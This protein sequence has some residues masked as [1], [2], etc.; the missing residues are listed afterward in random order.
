[1][2]RSLRF[3]LLTLLPVAAMI[4]C[5]VITSLDDLQGSSITPDAGTTDAVAKDAADAQSADAGPD[6]FI[7][8]S[9]AVDL[10]LGGALANGDT[11]GHACA[12]AGAER[13]LYCWGAGGKGQLGNGVL[14]DKA[15]AT[16]ILSDSASAAFTGVDSL[17]LG[18]LTSCAR[19][20]GFPYCWGAR[21]SGTV[22]GGQSSL[23]PAAA[24][25][26]VEP[27]ATQIALGGA[28]A[29][30]ISTD[31]FCWGDD[32]SYQLGVSPTTL[33]TCASGGHC[34]VTGLK[35]PNLS[36]PIAVSVGARHVCI[37]N[38][39]SEVQCWGTDVIEVELGGRAQLRA[40]HRPIR[41]VLGDERHG[42][43]WRADHRWHRLRRAGRRR[44]G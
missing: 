28:V 38:A 5:T 2:G 17:S 11:S 35:N 25:V 19:K 7:A 15:T 18:S 33:G 37:I 29:C 1:M 23:T 32:E 34:A 40:P 41:L 3:A 27:A 14:A 12:I 26:S 9:S 10:A 6:V 31:L 24:P 43:D 4:G 8:P 30:R 16:K 20:S 22:G 36:A 44:R 13:S 39:G 42:P 21:A